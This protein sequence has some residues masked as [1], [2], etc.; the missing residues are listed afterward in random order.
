MVRL[1]EFPEYLAAIPAADAG[2]LVAARTSFEALLARIES[3]GSLEHVA[4]VLLLLADVEARS[5]NVEK[6]LSLHER[7]IATDAFNPSTLIHCA[8]SLLSHLNN[9]ALA[10]SRLQ[11]AESLLASGKWQPSEHDMSRQ[12]YEREIESV[13]QRALAA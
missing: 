11:E 13:R 3:Q 4:F 10:L 7:A 12:W 8:K 5:G 2:D 9:V 6:A 1:S